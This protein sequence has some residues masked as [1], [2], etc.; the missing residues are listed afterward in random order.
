M[1]LVNYGLRERYEQIKKRGDKL[2]DIKRI[3]DWEGLRPLL[4]DPFTNDT[5]QGGRPNYDEILMVKILFLQS[6]YNIVDESMETAIYDSVRFIDFLDYPEKVPDHNTIWLFRERL[7]KTGTDKTLWKDICRQFKEKGITIRNGTIQDTTFIESDPG[8]RRRDNPDVVDPQMPPVEMEKNDSTEQEA[9]DKMKMAEQRAEKRKHSKTRRSK[10]GCWTEKNS[11]SYFGYKLHTIQ[12]VENDMIANYEV[13]TAS[14]HDSQRDL[15]IPGV[16]N[17]KDKGYFSV[18]GRGIDATIDRA[19]RNNPLPIESIRR[20]FRITRKRSR[21]ERPY[22]VMKGT[23][24]GDHTFVTTV[25]RV[26]VK[27]MFMCLGR[28]LFNLLSLKRRGKIATAIAVS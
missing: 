16:V 12:G 26:R 1:D 24:N 20:N 19:L 11:K 15:S 3:I 25:P 14:V 2:D 17:Y 10:D 8:H 18:E 6:I 21:G 28:N 23:F 7:S 4:T 27:A 9:K 13:T 5:D 22:S